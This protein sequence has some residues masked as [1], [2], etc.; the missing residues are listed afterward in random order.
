M[1][2]SEWI[3]LLDRTGLT[4]P[5][6]ELAEVLLACPTGLMQAPPFAFACG[7]LVGRSLPPLEDA[8]IPSSMLEKIH[9]INHDCF[10][11]GD[12]R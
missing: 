3:E 10:Q 12:Q 4:A 7:V 9:D 2:K 5:L 6:D 11:W 1:Q 8:P